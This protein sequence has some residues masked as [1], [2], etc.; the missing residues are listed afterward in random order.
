MKLIGVAG[1]K[2]SGADT[3]ARMIRE[4]MPELEVVAFAD[5]LKQ[6]C[7]TY[8]GVPLDT[9]YDD[10]GKDLFFEEYQLTVR[11]M[12]TSMADALK[13][14]YGLYIWVRPVKRRYTE[15]KADGAYGMVIS[16]VRYEYEA[17]WIRSEGGV[18]LHVSNS[19]TDPGAGEH[20]SEK[21]IQFLAGDVGL[22][23][24]GSLDYLRTQCHTFAVPFRDGV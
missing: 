20:S 19:R 3:V 11:E 14:Q 2:R 17:D 8:F 4:V 15:M 13:A 23:N 21:G 22:L 18:I 24:E 9:F 1:R 12:M 16:D 5:R 7:S 10:R 6:V